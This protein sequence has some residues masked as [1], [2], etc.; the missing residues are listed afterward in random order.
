MWLTGS[1]KPSYKTIAEFRK[2]SIRP[3]HKLFRRRAVSLAS[4]RRIP[5]RSFSSRNVQ[6]CAIELF[7]Q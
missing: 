2:H 7:S 5:V 6:I 1:L 3:L 4:T